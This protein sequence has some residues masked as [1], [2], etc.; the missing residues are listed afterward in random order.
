MIGNV[1]ATCHDLRMGM[2]GW[3]VTPSMQPS[4]NVSSDEGL[5]RLQLELRRGHQRI[6]LIVSDG[7]IVFCKGSKR[8]RNFTKVT[9]TESF[10]KECKKDG[11][12][13]MY[14]EVVCSPLASN[15]LSHITDE[16]ETQIEALRMKLPQYEN[17]T[18][19]IDVLIFWSG[20]ELTGYYGVFLDPGFNEDDC[21]WHGQVDRWSD[22]TPKTLH[23]AP[24]SLPETAK[25]VCRCIDKLSSLREKA[26][27]G[28]VA[29]NGNVRHNFYSMPEQYNEV[30]DLFW[31]Y[32]QTNNLLTATRTGLAETQVFHDKFHWKVDSDGMR[33]LVKYVVELTTQMRAE[34]SAALM[35]MPALDELARVPWVER[36][37]YKCSC[38]YESYFQLALEEAM[39]SMQ[40][41]KFMP[42][43][44][45][46]VPAEAWHEQE[47]AIQRRLFSTAKIFP[48][49]MAELEIKQM[50]RIGGG[51]YLRAD[52]PTLV[53]QEGATLTG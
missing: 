45:N 19:A 46:E 13:H 31:K 1:H 21:I 24:G 48:R 40:K 23:T 42:V 34:H 14:R 25:R 37:Y 3:S 18:L 43:Q 20:S 7:T 17:D 36:G 39:P 12:F 30:I 33:R 5:K 38:S 22:G 49:E 41:R 51:Q 44:L 26:H 47:L 8:K 52:D 32:A 4:Q 29:L 28:F 10:Q 9:P 11:G 35:G 15:T 6:L 53:K 27:V 50:V 16:L 2:P